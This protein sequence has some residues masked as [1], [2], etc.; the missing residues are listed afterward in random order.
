MRI[1]VLTD[2]DWINAN[3]RSFPLAALTQRGHE[4]RVEVES[5]RFT[6]D[7]V[8][9]CD[10][11]HVY[12]LC[13]PRIRT[14]LNAAR[15]AGAAIVWDEDDFNA[16]PT[17]SKSALRAQQARADSK[18]M[19]QLADLV[20]TPSAALADQYREWGA[21]RVRVIENYLPSS[22]DPPPSSSPSAGVTIGWTAAV[23]HLYDL[24]HLGLVDT[25]RRLLDEH[26]QLQITSIGIDLRL[27]RERYRHVM[28]VQY[29]ELAEHVAEFDIALAPLADID[30]NRARSNSK[31]KEYARAGVAWLA[32]PVGP[33]V[34]FGERE[35]GRLVPDDGWHDALT[36]LIVKER[37]RRKLAKRGRKWAAE[38]TVARNLGMWES[39]LAETLAEIR[40]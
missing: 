35:G 26:P 38:Q 37:D 30:F 25:L 3:Y 28:R 24:K 32:S 33:Y 6:T 27:P 14:I 4:V 31:L 9:G 10:V 2:R 12:R 8:R 18:R 40:R 5:E 11:V 23:E 7:S 17:T 21:K 19:L 13:E 29:H 39:A 16:T 36:R 20:T 22:Y 34:G 15:E 1:A